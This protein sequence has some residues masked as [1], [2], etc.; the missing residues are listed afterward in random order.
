MRDHV[1]AGRTFTDLA[2]G[3]RAFLDWVPLRRGQVHRTH[4]QVIG[5]RALIDHAALGPL[6]AQPYLVADAHLRRVGKDALVSF[7]ASLYSVPADRVRAGQRV[8][9]RS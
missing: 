6:P 2:D 9:V 4:G 7:Q 3:D 8:E 1:L 5:V